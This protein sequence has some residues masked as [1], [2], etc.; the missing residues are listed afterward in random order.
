MSAQLKGWSQQISQQSCSVLSHTDLEVEGKL[1]ECLIPFPYVWVS[2]DRV[3]IV[4]HGWRTWCHW[5]SSWWVL[6]LL[7]F[8]FTNLN[9]LVLRSPVCEWL[10][11]STMFPACWQFLTLAL[12]EVS[13]HKVTPSH[14]PAYDACLWLPSLSSLWVATVSYYLTSWLMT[15]CH[16]FSREW[17]AILPHCFKLLMIH[18]LGSSGSKWLSSLTLF[19]MLIASALDSLGSEWLLCHSVY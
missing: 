4:I 8:R 11:C 17:V 6:L 2:V 1:R 16:W 7:L 18:A 5:M 10:P 3:L 13:G 9:M 19:I 15:P 12:Q 14:K